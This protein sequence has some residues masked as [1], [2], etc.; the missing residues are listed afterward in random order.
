M[1][2]LDIPSLVADLQKFE[3]SVP[4]FLAQAKAAILK[5]E[6]STILNMLVGRVVTDPKAA[7]DEIV[8]CIDFL[9]ALAPEAQAFVAP[10]LSL[11]GGLKPAPVVPVVPGSAAALAG[12]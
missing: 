9:A 12:A 11:I 4:G 1:P 8:K 10:F 3:A 7:E 2:Q 6:S 5:A